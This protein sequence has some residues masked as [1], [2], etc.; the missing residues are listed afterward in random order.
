M[1]KA[2]KRALLDLVYA[3]R[4]ML[5]KDGCD[6][7]AVNEVSKELEANDRVYVEQSKEEVK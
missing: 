1:T 3:I 4:A 6:L 5:R 7:V 2:D